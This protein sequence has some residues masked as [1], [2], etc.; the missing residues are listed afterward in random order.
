MSGIRIWTLYYTTVG[1]NA[2]TRIRW[3]CVFRVNFSKNFLVYYD[4]NN[5]RDDANVANVQVGDFIGIT[6][7]PNRSRTQWG[8]HKTV[9]ASLPTLGS[10]NCL[11]SMIDTFKA[12]SLVHKAKLSNREITLDYVPHF[13]ILKS[14]LNFILLQVKGLLC[15]NLQ[16]RSLHYKPAI[17]LTY[18]LFYMHRK[19]TA[20]SISQSPSRPTASILLLICV[21]TNTFK[22]FWK[23]LVLGY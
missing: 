18:F 14:I 6:T 11:S 20:I 10:T 19:T 23:W 9:N 13:D 21:H 8:I 22:I 3:F 17:T 4:L 12:F 16:L 7:V 15:F 2:V 5:E 1:N